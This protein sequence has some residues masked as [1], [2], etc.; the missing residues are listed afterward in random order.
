MPE[1]K[2]IYVDSSDREVGTTGEFVIQLTSTIYNI[3]KLTLEGAIIPYSFY[4]IGPDAA[5]VFQEQ[6]GGGIISTPIPTQYYTPT[7]LATEVAALLNGTSPNTLTYTCTYNSSTGKYTI[8][9]SGNF[10]LLWTTAVNTDQYN[11]LY[12]NLGFNKLNILHGPD[13]DTGYGTSHVSSGIG[14]LTFNYIWI[15][16]TSIF[17]NDIATTS[18]SNVTYCVPVNG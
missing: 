14:S 15:R 5:I 1:K 16:I 18:S 7:T 9:S 6:A 12:Y 17:G 4:N 8:G 11:Y 10:G 3:K 2:Y 13:P